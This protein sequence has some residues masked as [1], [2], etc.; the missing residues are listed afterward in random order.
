MEVARAPAYC[1]RQVSQRQ[2]LLALFDDPARLGNQVGI[3][4]F[5]RSAL[6]ITPFARS[7]TCR[8][9]VIQRVVELHILRIGDPGRARRPA[10]NAR[11]EYRVP[12][13]AIRAFV[14]RNDSSPTRVV[15]RRKRY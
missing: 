12:E 11:R 13:M 5:E 15:R 3:L 9:S 1:V 4:A 2:L 10:I 6:G 14:A 7:E 8:A